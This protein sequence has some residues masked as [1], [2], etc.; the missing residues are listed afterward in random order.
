M[1]SL[2]ISL[3]PRIESQMAAVYLSMNLL[4]AIGATAMLPLLSRFVRW[5]CPITTEE[6]LGKP[7]FLQEQALLDGESAIDLVIREQERLF[8]RL[9]VYLEGLRTRKAQDLSAA[10]LYKANE[11]L[12]SEVQTFITELL[13]RHPAPN[14]S[15]RLLRRL[16]QEEIF[17]SLNE[18]ILNF[19]NVILEGMASSRLH[20][21]CWSFVES[22]DTVLLTALDALSPDK[23]DQLKWL[24]HL[25]EDRSEMM[26][27]L[28][29]TLLG[30]AQGF[31]REEQAILLRLTSLFARL[32][33]L[34]RQLAQLLGRS[35]ATADQ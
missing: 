5:L 32:I 17:R 1:K 28:H 13:N 11:S 19:A 15:Q 29:Q 20:K 22:L 14:L 31:S 34:L 27:K 7:Q 35:L 4:A 21:L 16:E 8:Q 24:L 9:P 30:E 3:F 25:T 12:S 6:A 2:C 23:E 10:A 26:E 33:W 18:G